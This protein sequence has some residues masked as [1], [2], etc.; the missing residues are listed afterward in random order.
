[1]TQIQLYI[2]DKLTYTKPILYSEAEECQSKL[3]K[4]YGL[5]EGSAKVK[6]DFFLVVRSRRLGVERQRFLKPKT[7]C[8]SEQNAIFAGQDQSK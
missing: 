4:M 6:W 7:V 3:K 5:F 2:N 1:M 8:N